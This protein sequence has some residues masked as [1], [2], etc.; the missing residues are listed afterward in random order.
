MKKLLNGG[1][2]FAAIFNYFMLFIVFFVLTEDGRAAFLLAIAALIILY[3]LALTPVVDWY[4]RIILNLRE[5]NE[6]EAKRLKR[7]W[8]MVTSGAKKAGITIKE[9]IRL[10]ISDE[11]GLNALATGTRTIAVHRQLLSNYITDE[12]IAGALAHELAHHIHGDTICLLMSMQ[13]TVIFGGIRFVIKI[14]FWIA[15]K[16]MAM[17]AAV[18]GFMATDGNLDEGIG[19]WKIINYIM[20]KI[21]WIIDWLLTRVAYLETMC[22]RFFGRQQEFA[23]DEFGGM[24]GYA[25]GLIM[26]FGKFPEENKIN[27]LS[28]EYLLY[29][30][31]PPTAE[32]IARLQRINFSIEGNKIWQTMSDK[33]EKGERKQIAA[34]KKFEKEFGMEDYLLHPENYGGEELYKAGIFCLSHGKEQEGIEWLERAAEGGEPRAFTELGCCYMKG[35]GVRTD[36][37]RALGYFKRAFANNEPKGIYMLAECYTASAKGE[38]DFATVMKIYGKAAKLGERRAQAKLGQCFLYG[39]GVERDEKAAFSWLSKAVEDGDYNMAGLLLAKCYLEGIGTEAN[40][41]RGIY[42]LKKVIDGGGDNADRARDMLA[43]YSKNISI[44]GL[45]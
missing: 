29:G 20:D 41:K 19:W 17:V 40:V 45:R 34:E 26:L 23:A 2:L 14:V 12:E 24:V 3:A 15:G 33:A 6:M 9:S 43:E 18:L 38:K 42:V 35:R 11:E 30:T 21:Y 8:N 36:L 28:I 22:F 16:L 32:R 1:F 7:V 5:P 31:H 44:T 10:Y 37:K 25:N 4:Y 27:K 39:S 13:G